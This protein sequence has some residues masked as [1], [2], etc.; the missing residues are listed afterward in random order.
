M[1]SQYL[2]VVRSHHARCSRSSRRSRRRRCALS[3][4]GPRQTV[5]R[6]RRTAPRGRDGGRR[7]RGSGDRHRSTRTPVTHRAGAGH[8]RRHRPRPA[9][10]HLD[11]ARLQ[12]GHP[13][14]HRRP[15]AVGQHVRVL[16]R[17]RD[18]DHPRRT[19]CSQ[20]RYPIRSIAFV[21]L[22]VALCLVGYALTLP[23]TI[24][25]LVPALENPPL[26]TIHVA[27][28]MISYGDLRDLVRGRG[29]LPRPGRATTASP[30]C[31]HG[32]SSTRS[33]TA[34]SSSASRSSRR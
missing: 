26:L 29:R 11:H 8:R 12:H 14:G 21:P 33:P 7:R 1:L 32:R 16:D 19:S 3:D 24:E 20:R 13:R 23:S 34:R 25:P 2:F 4:V 9:L 15:R 31:R 22:G 17:L 5:A 27:M 30:G 28:A 6:E 10:G 18:R